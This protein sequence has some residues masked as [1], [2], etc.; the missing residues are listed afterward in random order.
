AIAQMVRP[1]ETHRGVSVVIQATGGSVINIGRM[2]AQQIGLAA[3]TAAGSA[4]RAIHL[5]VDFELTATGEGDGLALGFV[6]GIIPSISPL[7]YR[8]EFES[9]VR[10]VMMRQAYRGKRY[11]VDVLVKPSPKYG[12]TYKILAIR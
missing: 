10:A 1:I 11:T 6:Q 4:E 5:G 2:E 9:G 8:V 3:R 12:N 7:T